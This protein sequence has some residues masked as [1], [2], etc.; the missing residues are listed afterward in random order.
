MHKMLYEISHGKIC[1]ITLTAVAE[2]TSYLKR[3]IVRLRENFKFQP[4]Q[5]YNTL[6]QMKDMKR[7]T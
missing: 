5:I 2:L 6:Y 7:K 3:I 1:R 4:C